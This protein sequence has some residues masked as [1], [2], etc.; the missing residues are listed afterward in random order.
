MNNIR[1]IERLLNTNI[2]V[3]YNKRYIG[4]VF[5]NNV[6]TPINLAITLMTALNTGQLTN[7]NLFSNDI[8]LKL[9]IATLLLASINTFFRPNDQMNSNKEYSKKWLEFGREFEKI[10]L[11]DENTDEEKE[12]KHELYEQLNNKIYDFENTQVISQNCIIDVI[13][14][15]A[16]ITCLYKKESWFKVPK[17]SDIETGNTEIEENKKIK[18]I[19]DENKELVEKINSMEMMISG[20]NFQVNHFMKF[21]KKE[22]ER[23]NIN[24][25]FDDDDDDVKIEEKQ[26]D[27]EIQND[28]ENQNQNKNDNESE[29]I[30]PERNFREIPSSP[31]SPISPIITERNF[32]TTF[33]PPITP[34]PSVV[35]KSWW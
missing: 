29:N 17:I 2:G 19:Q 25:Y 15:I 30:I 35:K 28:E 13:Y 24:T 20:I 5:W 27:K 12:K 34:E 16:S 4:S 10:F 14:F 9:N 1:N 21:V 22:C 32:I 23:C 31:F 8:L 26:N 3:S 7:N 6:S 11:M 18:I 33:P